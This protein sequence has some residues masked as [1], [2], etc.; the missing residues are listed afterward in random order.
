MAKGSF[1]QVAILIAG[2]HDGALVKAQKGC[3]YEV[4]FVSYLE[5]HQGIPIAWAAN[6]SEVFPHEYYLDHTKGHDLSTRMNDS[7]LIETI[8]RYRYCYRERRSK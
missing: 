3:L 1:V 5:A 8:D 7:G 2:P 6:Y 4:I